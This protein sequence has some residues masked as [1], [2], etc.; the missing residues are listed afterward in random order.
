[1]T[2]N[3]YVLDLII[4]EI[5]ILHWLP[6]NTRTTYQHVISLDILRYQTPYEWQASIDFSKALGVEEIWSG[7][8][9]CLQYQPLLSQT[10]QM[11]DITQQSGSGDGQELQRHL[12]SRSPSLARKRQQGR[13]KHLPG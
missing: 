8:R 3:C 1:L 13:W 6:I 9:A 4:A 2:F 7:S 12:G 11:L 5:S 10:P